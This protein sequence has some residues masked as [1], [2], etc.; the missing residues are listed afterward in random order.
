MNRPQ[1]TFDKIKEAISSNVNERLSDKKNWTPDLVYV[2]ATRLLIGIV[3]GFLLA[4]SLFP[5]FI[6]VYKWIK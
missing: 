1:E 4:C 2:H 3:M 6:E 5:L